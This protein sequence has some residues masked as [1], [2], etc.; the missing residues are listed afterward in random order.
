MKLSIFVVFDPLEFSILGVSFLYSTIINI[1][2][3]QKPDICCVTSGRGFI[4]V[5]GK[6]CHPF[7]QNLF[8]SIFCFIGISFTSIFVVF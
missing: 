3:F 4:V 2:N 1:F 5:G 6:I 8:E 7:S